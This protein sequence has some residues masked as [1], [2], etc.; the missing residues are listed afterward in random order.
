MSIQRLIRNFSDYLS[1][2]KHRSSHTIKSYVYD[3]NQ[4]FSI[5]KAT[6][7]LAVNE[8]DTHHYL[9]H[10]NALNINNRSIH[11]KMSALDQFWRYIV[12]E[13]IAP[14]NPWA[15]IRRPKLNTRL[16]VYLEEHA[17]LELLNNYPINTPVLCRNKA[18]L[19]LLFSSGIRLTELIKI[20]LDAINLTH[21]ECRVLGKGDKERLVIFGQRANNSI[22]YYLDHVRPLWRKN[23]D[24]T[25]FI[26]TR[27]TPLSG[28]SVQR[29]VKHANQYHSSTVELTPHTCRHTCATLLQSHGAGIRDIQELLGHSSISTTQ[30]Y[31][32][33]PNKTL[34]KR[35]LHAMPDPESNPTIHT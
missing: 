34:S 7:I 26:S 12:Q 32:H 6:D 22:Q 29:I 11:R 1:I 3:I 24:D 9:K 31:A 28:R 27:G 33:I 4:F 18:M 17:M 23:T 10:L 13:N 2:Q 5:T 25:L 19:D 30:R 8:Q 16:P 15:M 20:R 14:S 35:F 21:M